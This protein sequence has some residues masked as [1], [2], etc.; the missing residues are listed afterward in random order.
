MLLLLQG[1]ATQT[2]MRDA[3]TA[4]DNGNYTSAILLWTQLAEKGN[5][6]AQYHLASLYEQGE[7]IDQDYQ[8]AIKWYILAAEQNH[9]DA[10]INLGVIYDE[11]AGVKPDY[12]S[13]IKWYTRAARQGDSSAQYN[14]GSIYLQE[15]A[16]QDNTRAYMWWGISAHLGNVLAGS[17]L[18]QIED[19]MAPGQIRLARIMARKC[20]KKNYRGC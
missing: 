14:L 10:Q 15:D 7:G 17:Q 13:A 9:V 2:L 8:V 20:L 16:V 18:E 12:E 5:A 3:E 1:C 11:G 6:D 4:V 19:E